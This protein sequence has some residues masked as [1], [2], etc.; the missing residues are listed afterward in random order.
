MYEMMAELKINF[1]SEVVTIND[2]ENWG[3]LYADLFNCQIGLFP[4]KYLGVTVSPSRLHLSD[5]APLVDKSH[6][7][8]DI[9]K[10]V[11][12]PLL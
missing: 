9:W 5:W 12:C 10:G 7:R 6:K 1:N 8:L 3:S 4:I 11:L 2:T